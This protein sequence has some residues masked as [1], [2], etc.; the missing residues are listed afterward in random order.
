MQPKLPT[1]NHTTAVIQ[2]KEANQMNF[3]NGGFKLDRPLKSGEILLFSQENFRGAEQL[4]TADTPHLSPDFIPA[5]LQVGPKT[6]AT[7][8]TQE[9]FGGPS[10]ELSVDL[11]SFSGSK[12]QGQKPKSIKIWSTVGRQF[13]GWWAIEAG[14]GQY[15]S[16]PDPA[17]SRLLTTRSTVS[18]TEHFR[19]TGTRILAPRSGMAIPDE[20]RAA[21][22][23]PAAP[24]P[25]PL[26]VDDLRRFTAI[27]DSSA[28]F[29]RF[30]LQAGE[31][32]WVAYDPVERHFLA[33]ADRSARHIFRWA[34]KIAE[35]ETQVGELL[36]GEV[37]LYENTSYWGKAWIFHADFTDFSK[38]VGLDEQVSSIQLGPL[39]GA[40]IYRGAQFTG[41]EPLVGKQDAL[42]SLASLK[43]EQVDE[44]RISSLRIW[45]VS[46]PARQGVTVMCSLSQD[47]RYPKGS[48]KLDP[49]GGEKLEEYSAYRTTLRLPPDVHTVE[50]WATDETRIEVDG[51]EYLVDED[52]SQELHPNPIHCL[53]ITTDAIAPSANG[54]ARAALRTP[55]LKIRTNTMLLPGERMVIHPDREVHTRLASLKPD[56]LW[57]ATYAEKDGS[58]PNLIKDRSKHK[59]AD[60]DNAQE[61]IS[62]LMSTV[63]YTA[64][65]SGDWE[66]SISAD[67]LGGKSWA[68]DFHIYRVTADALHVRQGPG[69]SFKPVGYLRKNDL[70]EVLA[71][72]EEGTWIHLR[73]TSD[74]LEGW[75]ARAYLDEVAA[76]PTGPTGEKYRVT[77][78][79]LHVREGPGVEYRSLGYL[80]AG[81]TVTSIRLNTAGTWRQVIRNDGLMGWTSARYMAPLEPQAAQPPSLVPPLEATGPLAGAYAMTPEARFHEMSAEAVQDLLAVAESP[82]AGLAQGWDFFKKIA[83]AVKDGVSLVVTQVKKGLAVLIKLTDKVVGWIVDTAE[84]VAAFVEG[85]FEKIGAVIKEI[86]E[87]LKRLFDLKEI[88][89]TRDHLRSRVRSSL[90]YLGG[91]FIE[92][93]KELI[94]GFTESAEGT[95]NRVF[96]SAIAALPGGAK[97][98]SGGTGAGSG[99]SFEMPDT[100]EWI[101][102][103]VIY[104]LNIGNPLA[105]ASIGKVDLTELEDD[106]NGLASWGATLSQEIVNAVDFKSDVIK[107]F[108]ALVQNPGNPLMAIAQLIDALRN[109]LIDLIEFGERVVLGLLDLV[110]ALVKHFKKVL[111][112]PF[113]IPFL[114]DIVELFGLSGNL[115]FTLLDTATLIMAFPVTWL[116]EAFVDEAPFQVA[117]ELALGTKTKQE[118]ITLTV[119]NVL[120]ALGNTVSMAVELTPETDLTGAARAVGPGG[121]ALAEAAIGGSVKTLS[122]MEFIEIFTWLTAGISWSL[123]WSECMENFKDQDN[124]E[125]A[126]FSLETGMLAFDFIYFFI[127]KLGPTGKIERS[128]RGVPWS[129]W[130]ACLVGAVHTVLVIVKDVD[131]EQYVD[132]PFNIVKLL[133]ELYCPLRLPQFYTNPITLPA[134]GI[135]LWASIAAS[136][137]LIVANN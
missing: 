60:V 68:L 34:F 42:T 27:D 85:V 89:H 121:P 4:V 112:T 25:K 70:V 131:D 75:S 20:P 48:E 108:I 137:G 73:R 66:Q 86:I 18:E 46:S 3:Q 19:L 124:L 65:E 35:D 126:L 71:F 26:S 95:I 21:V 29:H 83:R 84:K 44:D 62:T 33:T 52:H 23:R 133:P 135:M 134:I 115:G 88:L 1:F 114:S 116:C 107:A 72:N 32:R 45:R 43:E 16:F 54:E 41:D 96:D 56:E 130:L 132:L 110:A 31:N 105:F 87:W 6:G 17:G 99:A 74:R 122:A 101:V 7:L 22:A 97:P 49:K 9:D 76:P 30:Y 127:G 80:A 128:K 67:A 82:D 47:F 113:R 102:S 98:G 129:I 38:V 12:L 57:N 109:R 79:G 91:E 15:L 136:M 24:Q 39:T 2:K 104:Y 36:Q 103:K 69:K 90:D 37:A 120:D 93:A 11:P 28:G 59:K 119:S 13:R 118:R 53:V 8:Y 10:Q 78:R 14:E 81:E 51:V 50:V 64:R 106:D 40:T 5:S 92:N 100:I 123:N 77:A 63:K 55:G 58:R 117:P 111:E 94:T 125:K 61:M